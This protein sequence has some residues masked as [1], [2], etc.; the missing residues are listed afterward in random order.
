MAD[1]FGISKSCCWR[2]LYKTCHRLLEV[3]RQHKI[4]SF[5]STQKSLQ[6]INEFEGINGFPGKHNNTR[7]KNV[8]FPKIDEIF[9]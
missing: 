1:R 9:F 6:I 8:S 2:I 5:P 4:I 3:N 7:G